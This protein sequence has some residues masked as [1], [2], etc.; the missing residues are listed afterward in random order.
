MNNSNAKYYFLNNRKFWI[1]APFVKFLVPYCIGII[2]YKSLTINFPIPFLLLCFGLVFLLIYQIN[3]NTY[4][5]K[6][7]SFIAGI[8]IYISLL[9][10][11]NLCAFINDPARVQKHFLENYSQFN[12]MVFEEVWTYQYLYRDQ[13]EYG[14][15]SP[16][17]EDRVHRIYE[18]TTSMLVR[19]FR[20]R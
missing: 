12:R 16:E 6:N 19:F 10:I 1:S 17:L 2:S 3:Q 20:S 13:A 8:Y 4:A 15:T 5:F 11:G 9:I 7:Q 14:R 18:T